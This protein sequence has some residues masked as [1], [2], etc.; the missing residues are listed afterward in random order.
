MK[1][2]I[3]L[4]SALTLLFSANAQKSLTI[5]GKVDGLTEGKVY[6]NKMASQKP[7]KI[8]SIDATNGSFTFTKGIT[9]SDIYM[10]NFG[11]IRSAVFLFPENENIVVTVKLSNNVIESSDVKAGSLQATFQDYAIALKENRAEMNKLIPLYQKA[12]SENNQAE[13]DRLDKELTVK[14]EAFDATENKI[15]ENNATNLLGLYFV[16]NKVY[17]YDYDKLKGTLEK[18]SDV[19]KKSEV[20]KNLQARLEKMDKVR[21]GSM[22]PDFTLPTPE[23]TMVS[24]SQFRGKVLVVDCWASWCGPCR[25]ENPNMVALYNANKDKNFTILG[26]SLD[27]DK[28]KWLKAIAD[29]KLTWNHVSDLKFWQSMICDLYVISAIPETILIDKDGKIVA[30]GLRGEELKAKVA[31][32]LK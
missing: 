23:G 17:Y 29:D 9:A 11:K 22:A 3:V 4:F 8:D 20:Y 21:V 32:L 27:R 25:A 7:I 1:K 18:V 16:I 30:R 15:Q 12:K 5:N 26:V 14:S 19:A 31:E 28:D 13:V 6:L 10:I 24:L 2:I